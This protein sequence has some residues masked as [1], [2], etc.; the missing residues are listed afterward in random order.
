MIRRLIGCAMV[1]CLLAV[2]VVI[3]GVWLLRAPAPPMP[4]LEGQ[5]RASSF[6]SGGRQ[7]RF[8]FYVPRRVRP[9]PPLLLVL[10][11]SMM[12]GR[13]MRAAT[14][15]TFD[16]IAD[17]EGF[18]VAYPD[19]YGGYWND[20]RRTGDT[21]AKRL[22]IDDV[23]FLRALV[24]WFRREHGVATNAVFA[25]GVSN[26]GQMSYRLGLEASDLVHGIAAVAANLPA[27]D[28]QS[29]APSGRP[30]ATMII[31]GTDD[32]LNPHAGGN[33]A[34]FG[35]FFRRGN[36]QSTFDTANYWAKLAGH[37]QPSRQPVADNDPDDGTTAT[38]YT[39]SG[40]AK[41]SVALIV[42]Q[43]GGHSLPHP[44]VRPQRLL[45]HTSHDFSAPQEIW[46][47]FARSLPQR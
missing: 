43:G 15:Y 42:V 26:G 14:G 29:C 33:A 47:F 34:L 6:E 5:L 2:V 7:R 32:P 16:E 38:R 17:R 12:D 19:G 39:W 10:H 24:D 36:V 45:G 46:K 44:A 1:L 21:T 25:T 35:L 41:P 13:R 37:A 27:A 18:L 31:N 22:A 30:V 20:C 9:D 28:N 11:S 4:R 40:G 23:A 3:L 8:V